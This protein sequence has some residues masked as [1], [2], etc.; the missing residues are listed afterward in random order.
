MMTFQT[1]G[2]AVMAAAALV[3][4]MASTALAIESFQERF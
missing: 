1:K 4:S 2:L 3:V